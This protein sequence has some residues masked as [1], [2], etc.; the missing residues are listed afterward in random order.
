M[1][2]VE[3]KGDSS[4]GTSVV[5]S[6]V[7]DKHHELVVVTQDDASSLNFDNIYED[8]RSSRG[9]RVSTASIDVISSFVRVVSPIDKS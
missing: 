4:N 1:K 9:S 6:G 8:T 3:L 5:A 2:I 7:A